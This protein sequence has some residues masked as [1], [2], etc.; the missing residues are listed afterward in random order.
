MIDKLK[1][2]GLAILGTMIGYSFAKLLIPEISFFKYFAIE[3][4][5]TL[6]HALYERT[7]GKTVNT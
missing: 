7:K 1:L 2:L 3:A 6:L 4:V 5:I